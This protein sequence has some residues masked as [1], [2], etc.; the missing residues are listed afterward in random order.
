MRQSSHINHQIIITVLLTLPSR[1]EPM[2]LTQRSSITTILNSRRAKYHLIN[3]EPRSQPWRSAFTYVQVV[4]RTACI[5]SQNPPTYPGGVLGCTKLTES[6][7]QVY[8][9]VHI[10]SRCCVFA[11]M[12][13]RWFNSGLSPKS[14]IPHYWQSQFAASGQILDPAA[15]YAIC[16]PIG[17]VSDACSC[18]SYS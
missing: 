11:V 1:T 10:T 5:V 8:L 3:K 15:P 16:F 14:A 17:A 13:T 2:I 12:I 7:V 4:T 6:I 9:A 18:T